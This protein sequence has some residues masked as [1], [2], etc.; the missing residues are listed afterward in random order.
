MADEERDG[1]AALAADPL[2]L[3]HR[4]NAD[5]TQVQFLRLDRAGHRAVTFLDERFLA[6]DLPRRVL[7]FADVARA[8]A[9]VPPA[10]LHFIFHSSFSLS[11]LVIRLLDLPGVAMGLKEPSIL[12]ETASIGR[13]GRAVRP[14]LEAILPLLARPFAPDEAV[15][16]KPADSANNLIPELM[17]IRPDARGLILYAPL[18]DFL[19]SVARRGPEG[20]M[21]FRRLFTRL[22]RDRVFDPGFSEEDWLEQIDLQAAAMTWLIQQARFAR[23]ASAGDGRLRTLDSETLLARRGEAIAALG[24]HF[25]LGLEVD[26]ILAGPIFSEHSKQL[27]RRFDA[28]ERRRELEAARALHGQEIAMVAGW[29]EAV[30]RHAGIPLTL[31][32]PLLAPS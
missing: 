6:A 11:T 30:A 21:V 2:W 13:G 12:S 22:R 25:G 5:A 8:A 14:L 20:R 24:L 19:A 1:L 31:P 28:A 10:P 32:R 9:A 15:V 18:P 26:A 27:G 16:I 4:I 3:P 29:A 23:L 17:R 7:P